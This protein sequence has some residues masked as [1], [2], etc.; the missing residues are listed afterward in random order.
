MKRL[1]CALVI[2]AL[3]LS[4]SIS[5]F[6]HNDVNYSCLTADFSAI[7]YFSDGSYAITRIEDIEIT[8]KGTV[9]KSKTYSYYDSSNVLQWTVILEATF[10]YNGSSATCTSATTGY[11]VSNSAWKVTKAN[12]SRSG[13]TATGDFTVKKYVLLV[14]VQTVNKTLTLTCSASGV[15]S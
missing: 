4:C 3:A 7:E 11:S 13:N 8:S 15:V 10:S 12:A 14:P 5:G 9:T 1:F 6:A 2:F